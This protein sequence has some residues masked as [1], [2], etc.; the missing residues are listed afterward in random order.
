MFLLLREYVFSA[1][2]ACDKQRRR[3]EERSKELAQFGRDVINPNAI[4]PNT[5][6]PK[7]LHLDEIPEVSKRDCEIVDRIRFDIDNDRLK[8]VAEY[9][10]AQLLKP[11]AWVRV[12]KLA[13]PTEFDVLVVPRMAFSIGQILNARA[14]EHNIKER[15]SSLSYFSILKSLSPI[16]L[17]LGIGIRL[18]RTHYDATTEARK[19]QADPALVSGPP[20][21]ATK[22]FWLTF[23]SKDFWRK[24]FATKT[25]NL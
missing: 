9:D 23:A 13:Y 17:G 14:E 2:F 7:V 5:S 21:L 16:L 11:S 24:I 10:M 8:T 12:G 20:T 25:I 6:P 18:A 22:N 15:L 3:D 19:A 4:L 1:S